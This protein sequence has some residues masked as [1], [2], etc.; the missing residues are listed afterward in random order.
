MVRFWAGGSIAALG[1]IVVT[2]CAPS[3]FA[4]DSGRLGL[5]LKAVVSGKELPAIRVKPQALVRSIVVTL[6]GP[7]GK[8]QKLK[9]KNLKPGKTKDL[10]FKQAIGTAKYAAEF[11]V[12]WGDK[13]ESRFTTAFEATRVGELKL[14]LRPDDVDIDGRSVSFRITNPAARAE[15]ILLGDRARRL[16][17]FEESYEDAAPGAVLKVAWDAVEE[18][19]RRIDLKVYDLAGFWVGMQ[20]TVIPPIEIPHE[21]VEFE[22]GKAVIR[23]TEEPKLESALA[24]VHER[25][26]KYGQLFGLKLYVA[27][28]TDTVGG[29]QYNAGLSLRR[30]RSIAGWFRKRGLKAAIYYQGFGESVLA[31]KTPDET[32]EPANR[33]AVYVLSSY[34]PPVSETIPEQAWKKL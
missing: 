5:S 33:R 34:T 20:I 32:P 27:G 21:D 2:V 26:A 23:S 25:M 7:N 17:T 8:V 29:R 15:V 16:G 28:Y 1:V 30:A 10:S 24:I 19:V 12:V 4:D 11:V 14:D 3:V 6:T 9:G 18:P 13:S 31:K 22:S